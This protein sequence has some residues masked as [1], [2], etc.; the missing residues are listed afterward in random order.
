[1]PQ[2]TLEFAS[3]MLI[4]FFSIGGSS[5][6]FAETLDLNCLTSGSSR[7]FHLV[8]DTTQGRISDDANTGRRR[9][10]AALV[11]EKS[12]SWDESTDFGLIHS[13]SHYDFDRESGQ[14]RSADKTGV[15]GDS[16]AV[17]AVCRKN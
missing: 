9:N 4:T 2:A 3:A 16:H 6:S 17:I 8:I 5:T 7:S 1:M 12:V 10:W 15:S 14:L 11:T 13:I